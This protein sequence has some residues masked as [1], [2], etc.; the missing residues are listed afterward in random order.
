MTAKEYLE[1]DSK[2]WSIID[3]NNLT[4][5]AMIEF[6]QNYHQSEVKNL[7]L[8]SVTNRFSEKELENV[9]RKVKKA[10]IKDNYKEIL[11]ERYPGEYT[12]Q[13]DKFFNRYAG[14]EVNVYEWANDWWIASDDNYPIDED[15]FDVID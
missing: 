5:A 3:D 14:Q 7:G 4:K 8:F 10:R 11:T 13:D 1:K 2:V 9:L 12:S 15:C 6:A